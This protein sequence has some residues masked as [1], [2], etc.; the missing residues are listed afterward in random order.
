MSYAEMHERLLAW[1]SAEERKGALMAARAAYFERF[2]E[3]HEDDRSYESRMNAMH[4]FYLYDFRPDGVDSTLEAFLRAGGGGL[5]ADDLARFRELSGNVHSLFEVRRLKPGEVRLRDVLTGQDHDVV[6]RR[7]MVGVSKGD[8]LEARLVPVAGRL[9]FSGALLYHP[10]QARKAILAEVKRLRK[11]AGRRGRPDAAAFLARLSRM[12]FKL[13]R[14][15][16][17][18]VESIYD[19][20]DP[21]GGR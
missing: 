7:A 2:G 8:L 13:E 15:R 16:N 10:P 17:V 1:A 12:A 21:A 9:H 19:F 11:E 5:P 14:Y 20:S 4:D 6:E 18:R 3:P